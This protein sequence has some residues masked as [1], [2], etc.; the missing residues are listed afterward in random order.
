MLA[1]AI[2][3]AWLIAIQTEQRILTEC[4]RAFQ[5]QACPLRFSSEVLFPA[6]IR[7]ALSSH[8]NAPAL[9]QRPDTGAT[10]DQLNYDTGKPNPKPNPRPVPAMMAADK[11]LSAAAD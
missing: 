2:R 3:P 1:T 5:P 6:L 7:S 9:G 8:K 4:P 10:V 11:V